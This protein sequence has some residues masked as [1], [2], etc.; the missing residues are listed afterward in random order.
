MSTTEVRPEDRPLHEDVRYLASTLGRVIER[1]EGP[2]AFMAVEGLR[3]A[4]RARRREEAGAK[5]FQALLEEV[6]A[7]PVSRLG[8]TARA[9]TL[10]FLLIN[11][12]EQVHRVRRRSAYQSE[13]KIAQPGSAR[14]VFGRLA[15]AGHTSEA[16]ESALG[17][18]ELR[19]VLTAHPTESTRRTTLSLL[20]RI[21]NALI[22]RDRASAETRRRIDRVLEAEVELLWLTSEARQDRPTV[23]HEV[24]TVLWYL[25]DRLL[26]AGAHTAEAY[27]TAFEQSFGRPLRAPI[28]L[29]MGSWVAGDRDGHPFV[30]PELT[31]E[32]A[33]RAA[34][35]VVRHH[36][37]A[38]ARLQ[39]ALAISARL[40]PG[41]TSLQ[42]SLA[43]DEAALPETKET[44]V[45][46]PADELVRAKL[47]YVRARLDATREV[48]ESR[49]RGELHHRPAAYTDV[50]A[51][52]RD[53]LDVNEALLAAHAKLAA[54]EHLAP[55]LDSLAS[56]GFFGYLLDVREDS[57]AHTKALAEIGALVGASPMDESRVTAE[58]A[59]LRPL[60]GPNLELSPETRRTLGVFGAIATIQAELG[61]TAAETYIISMTHGPMDLLRVLLLAKESGLVDLGHEPPRS[62][63]DV[64]PLFETREDLENGPGIMRAL[65]SHPTYRRQLAARGHRQEVMLGYSDSAKDAGVLAASWALYRAQ[66]DLVSV[67]REAGVELVLFHGR[68]GTV[69]R[70]GGSPVYRALTALPPGSLEG[71]IKV[72]EQGEV[73]SQKFGL[74]EI[75]ERSLE[76]LV[77]GCLMQRFSN[78]EHG[79]ERGT[80][81]EFRAQMDELS[82][83]SFRAFRALVHESNELFELFTTTTPVE[84]L[85]SAHFGSRPAYRRKG[86]G[87]MRGIR[88]IPW[89]FGWTQTRL[90]L[91][92]WLG[93][94]TALERALGQPGG[95]ARL[96]HMLQSWPFFD[97][98]LAKVEM[99]LAKCDLTVAR[100]YVESL[101]GD[102]AL[103]E[104]LEAELIRTREAVL[105]IRGQSAL[106][107]DNAMLKATIQLR[108]P[109]VDP[110][111]L[112]QISLLRRKRSLFEAH[113]D[114]PPI[115]EALSTTLSGIAQGLRNTG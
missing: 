112:I 33:R 78:W 32:A 51:L 100:S 85:A 5:S 52:E 68:G 108:N 77:A 97:D 103:F 55:L 57:E 12:A 90:M 26:E 44:L 105:T 42:A 98:L 86:A 18:L 22:E 74:P 16:I 29:R 40:A 20:A 70:G 64:V 82:E 109:Y 71:G 111:S 46:R 115:Q 63:I 84:E 58:L 65:F 62:A 10:F 27:R 34:L 88:A 13:A 28:R 24:G 3:A 8:T 14:W 91:P 15:E 69:G 23:M 19:P 39:D 99:V 79:L 83:H 60:V 54:E 101:G 80:I 47:S 7:W 38:V 76:V 21:S 36:L 94:G 30:T 48:L 49:L 89:V 93:V 56:H 11:T 67:A 114:L 31:L 72:T 25:E 43:R 87:S 113:P 61:P 50:S 81:R 59:G 66:E 104:T 17:A 106:L 92:G 6:S 2:E 95:K 53:L 35:T 102:M 73:I 9:F 4:C 110:L 41:T 96:Q 75:A 1:I 37:A 45:H 107:H